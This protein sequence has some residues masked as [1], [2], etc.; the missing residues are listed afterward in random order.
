MRQIWLKLRA[1]DWGRIL[2]KVLSYGYA[3]ALAMKRFWR[4]AFFV[5]RAV[6]A[7]V[8]SIGNLTAGGS[9][10]TTLVSY[11]ARRLSVDGRHVCVLT[12]GYHGGDEARLIKQEAAVGGLE[13]QVVVNANRYQGAAAVY[14]QAPQS[15][16]QRLVFLMDDGHQH[17]TLRKNFKIVL[18]DAMDSSREQELLPLGLW[19]EPLSWGL[20]RADAIIL[21]HADLADEQRIREWRSLCVRWALGKPV[22][23][24]AQRPLGLKPLEGLARNQAVIDGGSIFLVSGIGNP[25]AFEIMA[26]R[27]L[28]SQIVGH[29]RLEDHASHTITSVRRASLEAARLKAGAIV[30]TA[31]DAVKITALGIGASSNAPFWPVPIPWF[32]LDIGWMFLDSG[33][34]NFWRLIDGVIVRGKITVS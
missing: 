2:L 33:E 34:E 23:L 29:W 21:T 20:S 31:K 13:I 17:D 9:G 22:L 4:R 26:R 25:E 15:M 10:K 11:M 12:R 8:V 3:G 5:E 14:R 24:A 28:N 30:T 19:R 32:L 7:P 27:R 1:S 6:A 18:I 16:R